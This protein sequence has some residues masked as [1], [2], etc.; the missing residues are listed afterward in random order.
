MTPTEI[1]NEVCRLAEEIG[2]KA[3]VH[4]SI[5]GMHGL[6]LYAAIYPDGLGRG[7]QLSVCADDWQE[8]FDKLRAGWAERCADYRRET[9]RRMALEIIRITADQGV[10]TD[11][12]LR[13]G[14]FS[15]DEVSRYGEE[16]CRD[17]NEIAGK[18][19]FSITTVA[20]ANNAPVAA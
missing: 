12:A 5:G 1:K 13:A 11:A 4:V 6:A 17:A 3:H 8:L 16:A 19:P 20:G 7:S 14:E 9:I 18:G 2:D 15:A 10:C